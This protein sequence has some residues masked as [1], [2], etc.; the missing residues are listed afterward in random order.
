MK[1]AIATTTGALALLLGAR[2]AAAAPSAGAGSTAAADAAKASYT[3]VDLDGIKKL[4]SK[5]RGHVVL[6]HFWASWCYPCLQELPVVDRLAR[7]YKGRGL[8][9]LSVS[10]DNPRTAGPRVGALLR[11]VAPNLTPAIAKFDDADGFISAFD[12]TWEGAIPA[13]FAFD[14]EGGRVGT[15]IG[16]STREELE[17]FVGRWLKPAAGAPATP[18]AQ[19]TPAAAPVQRPKP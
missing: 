14:Q 9:V 19:P 11:K 15:L 7:D 12:R 4:M 17:K 5:G 10:L 8:E 13:M 16:E 2:P 6:V 18:G 3:V 1:I